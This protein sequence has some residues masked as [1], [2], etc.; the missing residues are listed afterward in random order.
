MLVERFPLVLNFVDELKI[1]TNLVLVVLLAKQLLG[2]VAPFFGFRVA[3]AFDEGSLH[4]LSDG[5][6][7]GSEKGFG[8]FSA[9]RQYSE[10]CKTFPKICHKKWRGREMFLCSSTSSSGM[11]SAGRCSFLSP[12][13]LSLR[14]VNCKL[15]PVSN[16]S[17]SDSFMTIR[18]VGIAYERRTRTGCGMRFLYFSWTLYFAK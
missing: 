1:A 16:T 12:A 15:F 6:T 3:N 14:S 7:D 5:L 8:G 10:L 2:F 18:G 9:A 17:C 13:R 11:K 4:Y